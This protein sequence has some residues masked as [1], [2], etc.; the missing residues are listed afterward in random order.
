MRHVTI[1]GSTGSV[2]KNA[3]DIIALHKD[4]F[5]VI[6]LT[7]G[8]NI[9]LLEK[10]IRATAPKVVAVADERAAVKLHRRIKNSQPGLQILSGSGG[11]KDAAALAESDFVLSAIVGSAGLM[12][13]L[14]AIRSGKIVGLANK[15]SLVMAGSILINEAREKSAVILPVDSEHSAIFQCIA[16]HRRSDVE[17]IILTASGGPFA[18]VDK[19]NLSAITPKQALRHPR[20]KMGK[21]ITIDSATL[22]NKGFEIIEAHHLFGL[23]AERIDVLVHTESIVHSIVEFNDRSCIAQLSVPD[24]KGPIAYA[25][26]YPERLDNAV[27]RLDL[28]KIGVLSFKKPDI[29]RFPCLS[30]AYR[31]LEAGGTMPA[32][33]N[34]ANEVAVEAFLSG[35]AGFTDIP[36][37][38]KKVMD[39]HKVE[40]ATELDVI[41][42]ADKWA[43]KKAERLLSR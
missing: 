43:R 13:T 22:M 27:Q 19:K 7:A 14:S 26:M 20:W 36:V 5:G 30:Y 37:I 8:D 34:A 16:G 29:G 23:P 10:Q 38:I 3:L 1:L 31:A 12:P 21:K 28:A 24:M 4:K 15:E 35:R 17:K 6:A 18:N 33:L 40:S 32:V 2:G 41:L 39:M 11:I 9:D 42:E 25:L